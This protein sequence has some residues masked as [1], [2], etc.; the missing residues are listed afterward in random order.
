MM[1]VQENRLGEHEHA[2]A[3]IG[4]PIPDI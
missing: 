4:L 3:Q 2:A 1:G